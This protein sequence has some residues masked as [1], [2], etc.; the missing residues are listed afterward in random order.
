MHKYLSCTISRLPVL[1]AN[2]ILRVSGRLPGLQPLH[3]Q[4]RAG[5]TDAA[6]AAVSE[7][8]LGLTILPTPLIGAG[9][10]CSTAF[11]MSSAVVMSEL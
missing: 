7:P 3:L 6:F 4:C 2:T 5:M 8:A 11:S 9:A 10:S 1:E